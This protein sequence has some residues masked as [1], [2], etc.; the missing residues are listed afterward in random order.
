VVF[1]QAGLILTYEFKPKFFTQPLTYF[2]IHIA[3]MLPPVEHS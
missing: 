1:N 3:G 2:T